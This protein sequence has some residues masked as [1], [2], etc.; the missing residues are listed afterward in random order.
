[1]RDRFMVWPV[2]VSRRTSVPV[3]NFVASAVSVSIVGPRVSGALRPPRTT[4]KRWT[5]GPAAI[6]AAAPGAS[7]TAVSVIIIAREAARGMALLG[8]HLVRGFA[9]SLRKLDLDLTPT[10]AFPVQVVQSVFCISD[11]LKLNVCK[12]SWPP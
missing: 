11:I 9:I 5:P 4:L 3:V 10:N 12:S 1:M 7:P 8:L 2:V 6:V